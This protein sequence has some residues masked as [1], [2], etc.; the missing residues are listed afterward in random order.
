MVKIWCPA[1]SANMG[2][3]FDIAGFALEA[4]FDVLEAEQANRDEVIPG[5]GFEVP[6][7]EKNVCL[8]VLEAIRKDC[9]IR[10]S[11]SVKI[12]KNIPPANG[13]GSSGASCA[14]MAIA[15]NELFDLGLSTEKLIQYAALGETVSSGSA[16]KNNVAPAITG[17]VCI[18]AR[19]EPLRLMRF[20]APKGLKIGILQT[21]V[22]KPSTEFARSVLPETVLRS[23]HCRVSSNLTSLLC[24]L[25]EGDA[26]L[27]VDSLDDFIVEPAREKAGILPR[28]AALKQVC[29]PHGFGATASGSG[30]TLM[31]AGAEGY[32]RIKELEAEIY[33]LYDGLE[34][35]LSW[36]KVSSR[37][38]SK[39]G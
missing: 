5:S 12:Q 23:E 2:S 24:S 14:G 21:N 7:M 28:L 39:I 8:P 38:C 36:T 30:P 13:L 4:P 6:V 32:A 19:H 37:G 35:K 29:R 20:D 16:I 11:V 18:I 25:F 33:S 10:Q 17:G 34:P 15:L 22:T 31:V 9:G 27:F 3:G 26:Q 1:T